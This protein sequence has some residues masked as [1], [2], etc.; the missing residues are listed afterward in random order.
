[1]MER[2]YGSNRGTG[3]RSNRDRR[4]GRRCVRRIVGT[5]ARRDHGVHLVIVDR[6]RF[7]RIGRRIDK[8]VLVV[9]EVVRRTAVRVLAVQVVAG[10]DLSMGGHRRSVSVC[11]ITIFSSQ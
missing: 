3:H 9:L 4:D 11:V 6:P 1:M 10:G 7:L 2:G 5:A 8:V